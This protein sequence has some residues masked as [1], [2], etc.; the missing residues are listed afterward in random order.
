MP[1]HHPLPPATAPGGARGAVALHSWVSSA[2]HPL[3]LCRAQPRF[4]PEL[5]GHGSERGPSGD[6]AKPQCGIWGRSGQGCAGWPGGEQGAASTAPSPP[7]RC[8]Q[9]PH[10]QDPCQSR[11][12]GHVPKPRLLVLPTRL[13]RVRCQAV[14]EGF[15]QLWNPQE[16]PPTRLGP[17]TFHPAL[18]SQRRRLHRHSARVSRGQRLLP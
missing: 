7:P 6:R 1:G 17:H 9:Q 3:P 12:Q 18:P 16:E 11:A 15:A 8:R 2:P 4:A 5:L 14:P 13:A 10:K